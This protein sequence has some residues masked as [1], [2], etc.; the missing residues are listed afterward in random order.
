MGGNGTFAA[1]KI[2]AY[3]WK[4]VDKIDG[5][6]VLEPIGGSRKLPEEAHSSR[7]YILNNADGTFRQLRVYDSKHRLRFEIGYHREP[8]VDPKGG[9]VLHYHIIKQPG[10]NHGK[11]HKATD[12]MVRKFGKYM[13]GVD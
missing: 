12:A 1:G 9:K 8:S 6:K 4:T 7:M 2:V 5:A 11:A 13:R 10:F 3:K